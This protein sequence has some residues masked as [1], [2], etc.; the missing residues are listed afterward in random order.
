M[1]SGQGP[2]GAGQC[3]YGIRG[4]MKAGTEA[5]NIKKIKYGCVDFL[6]FYN[7]FG[8]EENS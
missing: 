1:G 2:C 3:W 5:P 4:M 6:K 8:N 7:I